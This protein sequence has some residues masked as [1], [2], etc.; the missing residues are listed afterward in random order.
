MQIQ[1]NNLAALERLIGGDSQLEFEIRNNIVQ[2]FAHKHLKP[3]AND[4]TFSKIMGDVRKAGETEARKVMEEKI[5]RY[6]K[7]ARSDTFI[8]HEEQKQAIINAAKS[9]LR[10]QVDQIV[11]STMEAFP[12]EK[13]AALVEKR[14]G[15]EVE[16]RIN[17]G[18][19]NK[20][21]E[22]FK[23]VN[24]WIMKITLELDGIEYTEEGDDFELM[25]NFLA[26][27]IGLKEYKCRIKLLDPEQLRALESL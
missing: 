13:I 9:G 6:Q 22:M 27:T 3:L 2:A 16:R 7:E 18:V 19:K 21:D 24:G 12:Q 17:E 1:I 10:E 11:A 23:K 14:V 25:L 8:L 4:Q 26:D 20:L 5:G 15:Q